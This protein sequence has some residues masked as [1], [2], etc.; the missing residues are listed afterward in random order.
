MN[1]K[2][3]ASFELYNSRNMKKYSFNS[4]PKVILVPYM[5]LFAFIKIAHKIKDFKI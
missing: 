1:Y 2:I 3:R 4:A 5:N